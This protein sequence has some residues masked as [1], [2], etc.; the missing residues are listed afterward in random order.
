MN[1]RW[2]RR[3]LVSLMAIA[4]LVTAVMA[5]GW[6]GTE[7][8]IEKTS[9]AEFCG[10]CH[11]MAPFATAHAR[12]THGGNNPAGV[13][14]RCTDCHLP[15]DTAANHL[16]E[17]GKAGVRDVIAQAIY[18]FYKPDWLA[19]LEKRSEYVYDSGC[20]SCHAALPEATSDNPAA[21]PA[22]QAYFDG[23]VR[24][25]C[26]TCHENVGHKNLRIILADYFD[27]VT[28]EDMPE[29]NGDTAAELPSAAEQG[30][31]EQ[32]ATNGEDT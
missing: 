7:T 24:G 6:I 20:L 10:S 14:A 28:L 29:D 11:S 26:V 3:L 1:K 32:T 5:G 16:L 4:L 27:E 8:M 17:K 25:G 18:P 31:R 21:Q 9:G 12:D 13:V 15:H 30:T 23:N 22:H 2:I 19:R